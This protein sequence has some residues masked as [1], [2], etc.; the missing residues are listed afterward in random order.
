MDDKQILKLEKKCKG[1]RRMIVEMLAE[2]GGGHYGGS[3]SCVEI[4]TALY[5]HTLKIDPKNPTWVDRDRFVLSK[6][7]ACAC[8]VC[9]LADRGYFPSSLLKTFNKLDSPFGQ[10]PDMHKIE[11]CD[12]STGSLGH[13]PPIGIGMALAANLDKRDYRV[14]VLV[15][16]G[17]CQEGSVW[18]AAMA[19]AHY[20]LEHLT[21]IVDRNQLSM[22][23]FTEEIMA[24]G[25]LRK[26]FEAFGW[27]V[28]EVDGHNI[29]ALIEALDSVPFEGKRPSVII[30]NTAKAKGVSCMENRWEW[31]YNIA[32]EEMTKEAL[33]ELE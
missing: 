10:H 20:K 32:S 1:I 24:L 7:H 2:A 25:D 13:G 6:G 21:M 23:G 3:L 4:L 11:G 19:A 22:D 27:A 33:R 30:A 28:R 18:E 26:K 9:V 31:H 17:E 5:F 29:K 12:M 15:G 14:F 16:D 8:L